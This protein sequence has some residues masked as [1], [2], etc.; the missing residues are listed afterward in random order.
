MDWTNKG[1]IYDPVKNTWT[2]VLPPT[3]WSQIGDAQS[4]VLPNGTFMLGNING[5]GAA[6]LNAKTLTWTVIPGTG[7]FD[8]NDEEG[9][10][11]L[12]GGKVLTV[13]T[14]DGINDPTGMNSEI[15]NTSTEAWTSA[16]STKVQL[17]DSRAACGGKS[18]HEV[19]PA[20]LMYDGR[21]FA[22]G[23]NT[24]GGAGHTALYDTTTSVW[25]AGPDIPGV[26]DVADGPAAILPNGHVLVDTNAGYG[27]SPTTF[28][29]FNGTGFD[30]IPQPSG[31]TASNTEGHRLLVTAAGTV[32]FTHLGLP[33]MWFFVPTGG[34]K[35]AWEPIITS[36][37][38][39]VLRGHTY[40]I[41]GVQF[42]GLS[43]GAMFG[44]DAQSA[45]NYPL[46]L[47]TNNVSGHKIFARTHNF[48]SMA[49]AS[50]AVVSAQFDVPAGAET[51][52]NSVQVIANGIPSNAL[53]IT[54]D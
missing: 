12:P 38:S 3:G 17:W 7:K 25:S 49:V 40:T 14:Y 52:G 47:I 16:G 33:E 41:K 44:D 23:A 51:G 37:P 8:R 27:H 1:A 4:V 9:W 29:S 28:Y 36:L 21:V 53:S 48:S 46:V 31:L 39:S 11:L 32:L 20:V 22:T 24:C 54:I 43:Q 18:T 13:D 2:E 35:A 15:F 50:G 5:A 19:G 30:T 10:T 34:P 42:N 6:L 45:T 26:N